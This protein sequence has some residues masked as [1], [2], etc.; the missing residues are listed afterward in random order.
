VSTAAEFAGESA[1]VEDLSPS[2]IESFLRSNGWV[3]VDHRPGVCAIW[4]N[5][6]LDASLMMPY[7][8]NFRDFPARLRD[9]LRTISTVHEISSEALPVE[10]AGARNDIMFLRADQSGC[11][12][13]LVGPG[14]Q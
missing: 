6:A 12:P 11:A 1:S 8:R 5:D 3:I 13:G 10:I 9:A 7:N 2:A 4:E 14:L